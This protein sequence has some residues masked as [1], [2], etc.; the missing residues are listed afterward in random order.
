M[1]S[2]EFSNCLSKNCGKGNGCSMSLVEWLQL[3]AG[4]ALCVLWVVGAKAGSNPKIFDSIHL[5]FISHWVQ[6]GSV[7]V[8][9]IDYTNFRFFF[10]Y[11]IL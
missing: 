4:H 10:L 9:D 11:D 2:S 3:S 8:F 5:R 7:F 6:F 1:L